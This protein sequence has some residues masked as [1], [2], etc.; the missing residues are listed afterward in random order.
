MILA[1]SMARS[2][3]EP[4]GG[5]SWSGHQA[6]ISGPIACES[7]ALFDLRVVLSQGDS[8]GSGFLSGPCLG[9]V[10][11]WTIA[12]S[13]LA[14]ARFV[15]GPA[16]G[17]TLKTLNQQ[18]HQLKAVV[19]QHCVGGKRDRRVKRQQLVCTGASIA[20]RKGK[21]FSAAPRSLPIGRK[22]GK[23]F[24]A[25]RYDHPKMPLI[26]RKDA[27][28]THTLSRRHNGSIRQVGV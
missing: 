11:R 17:C 2:A 27:P 4:T 19:P 1:A 20:H 28:K 10:Q 22:Q 9:G 18:G 13:T 15:P 26:E 5:L 25:R 14:G 7:E 6:F 12:V 16:L 3:I 23:G 21:I 8:E 24:S